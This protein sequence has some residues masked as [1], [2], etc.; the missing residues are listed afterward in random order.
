MDRWILPA[1]LGL[2][3]LA[4]SA[5]GAGNVLTVGEEGGAGGSRS[6]AFREGD[7][8]RPLVIGADAGTSR[9]LSAHIE[10]PRGVTVHFVTLACSDACADVIA[11]AEGG[12]APYAYTWEDGT[13]DPSRHVCPFSTTRYRVTVT[14]AGTTSGELLRPPQTATADLTADVV[15]CPDAGGPPTSDGSAPPVATPVY[16]ATWSGVTLGNAGNAHGVL[17]PPGGDVQVTFTGEV[18]ASSA[19]TGDPTPSGVGQVLFLPEATYTSPTVPNPPPET[20]M[21]TIWDATTSAQTVT[22]SAPVRDPLVA[23][24]ALQETWTFDA[25]PSVLSSGP[26]TLVSILPLP[27]SLTVSG[28]DLVGAVG[29]GVIQLTGTFSSIHFTVP[30]NTIGSFASFTV[31]IRGRG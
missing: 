31:G 6:T 25:P 24:V 21:I 23:V 20:G 19:K 14:D 1:S 16:W 22:F 2:T 10:S 28:N 27:S 5:G 17:S 7:G 18:G 4:C 29:N 11:V 30:K 13:M 15:H 26:N 3:L 8:G 12:F 9:A